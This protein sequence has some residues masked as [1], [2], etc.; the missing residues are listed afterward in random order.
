[1]TIRPLVR[2]LPRRAKKPARP[3]PPKLHADVLI[4]KDSPI[5]QTEIEVIAALLEDWD[6]IEPS[7]QEDHSK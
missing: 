7:A 2:N 6:G 5:T 4:A 1:M 3:K